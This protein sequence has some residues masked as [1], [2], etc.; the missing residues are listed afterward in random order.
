M[1]MCVCVCVCM[2]LQSV[3]WCNSGT[4]TMLAYNQV[5]IT[6]GDGHSKVQVVSN[7]TKVQWSIRI[8]ITLPLPHY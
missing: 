4:S 3:L 2:C 5:I 8:T 6:Y 7:V 1:W